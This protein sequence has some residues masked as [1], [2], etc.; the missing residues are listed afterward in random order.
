M[1]VFACAAAMLAGVIA[2][3]GDAAPGGE[4]QIVIVTPMQTPTSPLDALLTTPTPT[5]QVIQSG[6]NTF[7]DLQ[8]PTLMPVIFTPTPMGIALGVTIRVDVD[9]G[10]N[11]RPQPTTD[12][13]PLFQAQYGEL[14]TVVEG[15]ENAQGLTWWRIESLADPSRTGWAAGEFLLVVPPQ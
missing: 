4:P 13:T 12:N 3:G 10:L 11:V 15:P 1:G 6:D 9:G 7:F 2:L 14:F 8:G 5:L